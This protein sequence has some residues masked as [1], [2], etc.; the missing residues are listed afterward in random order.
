MYVFSFAL[1]INKMIKRQTCFEI[2]IN[3]NLGRVVSR[4]QSNIIQI[5]HTLSLSF[6]Y[7]TAGP[8]LI[9]IFNYNIILT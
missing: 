1:T 3:I 4:K 9:N 7:I 5:Y 2:I 6:S 8:L